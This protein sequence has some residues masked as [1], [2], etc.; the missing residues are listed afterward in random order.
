MLLDDG[1]GDI[2]LIDSLNV[3]LSELLSDKKLLR[4]FSYEYDFGDGWLHEIE[5]EGL[6]ETPQ[7]PKPPCCIDGDRN[8]PPEDVGGVWGYEDFLIAIRDPKH[9]QHETY[10]EW[11]G[12]RVQ[13]N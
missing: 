1:F 9:E 7:K 13:C 4:A 12:R 10:L 3:T 2:S 5:F 8:C 11:A 6:K